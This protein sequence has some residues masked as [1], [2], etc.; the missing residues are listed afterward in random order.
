[1]AIQNSLGSTPVPF[2]A[3]FESFSTEQNAQIIS[4]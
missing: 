1:M 2:S 4:N 3:E